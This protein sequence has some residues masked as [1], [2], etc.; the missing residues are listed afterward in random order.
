MA[1][2][3]VG[4]FL[5]TPSAGDALTQLQA[6]GYQGGTGDGEQFDSKMQQGRIAVVVPTPDPE[7]NPGQAAEVRALLLRAGALDI[8]EAARSDGTAPTGV[9]KQDTPN[10]GS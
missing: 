10:Q 4:F 3:L 8:Q 9:I 1:T 5:D 7:T 6:A 2:S